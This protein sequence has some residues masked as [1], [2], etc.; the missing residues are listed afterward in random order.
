MKIKVEMYFDGD[1]E[2]HE[3]LELAKW[4]LNESGEY[5]HCSTK[6]LKIEEIKD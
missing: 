4:V 3:M 6:V 1:V 2:E 5:A